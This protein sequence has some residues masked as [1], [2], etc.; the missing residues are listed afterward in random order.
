V[1]RIIFYWCSEYCVTNWLFY[2][3]TIIFRDHPNSP[4]VRISS[5]IFFESLISINRWMPPLQHVSDLHRRLGQLIFLFREIFSAILKSLQIAPALIVIFFKK[6][7]KIVSNFHAITVAAVLTYSERLLACFKCWS[8][9]VDL[10]F[11]F[12]NITTVFN[13]NIKNKKIIFEILTYRMLF[14][15]RYY[16][17]NRHTFNSFIVTSFFFLFLLTFSFNISLFVSI[18]THNYFFHMFALIIASN[19]NPVHYIVWKSISKSR[20][21]WPAV[22]LFGVSINVIFV[23]WVLL[24]LLLLLL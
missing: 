12:S 22:K 8:F 15:I 1:Y 18:H 7:K 10:Y 3:W 20:S 4:G 9:F 17:N 13:R 14:T 23:L 11:G 16:V 2:T 5:V 6:T 19:S 24:L 21:L